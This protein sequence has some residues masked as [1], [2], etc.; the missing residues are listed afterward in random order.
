MADRAWPN[1][2]TTIM[3]LI[4]PLLPEIKGPP[5][6]NRKCAQKAEV[7]SLTLLKAARSFFQKLI[8]YGSHGA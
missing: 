6:A 5:R 4:G 8:I 3:Y 2:L 1:L 7:Q